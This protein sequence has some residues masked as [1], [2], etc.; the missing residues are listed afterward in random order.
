MF[1]EQQPLDL[2]NPIDRKKLI[3]QMQIDLDIACR[4]EFAED[5]RTHLGASV[6]GDDC[7]A[8]AWNAFRWLKFEEANGQ[9]LR[10]FNRGHLEEARFVRWL[11]LV[12]FEVREFDPVTKKQFRILGCKGHFGGSLDAM[13]KPPAKYGINEDLIFLGEFKTHN[14]KNFAKLAGPKPAWRDMGKPRHG[15]AGVIASK[16]MHFKQMCSYGRAYKFKYGLYCAVN[17]DTDELYFEI[18]E[19]DWRQADDLFRKA[20]GIVFSQTRPPKIANVASFFD[21]KFC[22]FSGLCHGD[23]VP[24]KNCRSC[25]NA[26][27]VEDAQWFCQVHQSN[28]PAHI[29]KVGCDSYGRIA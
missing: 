16:P 11:E 26:F 3:L 6:I 23:E 4:A 21:C 24:V 22:D 10:L 17:K 14:E 27:P 8:K 7:Q 5:P 20:E 9:Q 19:L 18:V 1:G 12:G 2:S 29:I 13:A 28:I 15:G 25:R